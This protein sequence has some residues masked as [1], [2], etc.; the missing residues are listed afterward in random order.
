MHAWSKY[1]NEMKKQKWWMKQSTIDAGLMEASSE[2]MDVP[3]LYLNEYR[4]TLN[5]QSTGKLAK[6][7]LACQWM[8]HLCVACQFVATHKSS[9]RR[10]E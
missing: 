6:L 2:R 1:D 5:S 8:L 10:C 4:M 9:Q 3:S 7:W